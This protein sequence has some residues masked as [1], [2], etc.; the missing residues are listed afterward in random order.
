MRAAISN[1]PRWVIATKGRSATAS[2][3]PASAMASPITRA[4][5]QQRPS[6]KARNTFSRNG[7]TISRSAPERRLAVTVQRFV[8]HPQLEADTFFIADWALSRVLL[9]NDARFPWL[10]LVPRRPAPCELHDL[11]HA[12]RMVLIEELARAGKHLKALTQAVKINTAALGN[13][14]PQLHVHVVARCVA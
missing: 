5:M 11:S 7:S 6:P 10:I 14:V 4:S 12:E 13:Q 9:M 3:L 1:F 2:F 8:L